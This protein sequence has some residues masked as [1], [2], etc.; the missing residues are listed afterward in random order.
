MT[1]FRVRGTRPAH[2]PWITQWGTLPP[3]Q[4]GRQG[5]TATATAYTGGG[6]GVAQVAVYWL[7]SGVTSVSLARVL[8]DGTS[9]TVRNS[10]VV[11][12]DGWAVFYD[13]E[14][15]LN[16]PVSYVAT[17]DQS[18]GNSATSA[19]L[20]LTVTGQG[21]LGDPEDPTLDV[22]LAAFTATDPA[23][24]PAEGVALQG[25]DAEKFE[26]RSGVFP[27]IGARRPRTVAQTRADA[28][29]TVRLV[30]RQLADHD[31]VDDL[32]AEGRDLALRLSTTGYGW[33]TRRYGAGWMA[34]GDATAA[35]LGSPD[36]TRA[37]RLWALPYDTVD[38]PAD[39]QTGRT[40]SNGVAVNGATFADLAATYATFAA[41][42]AAGL[43]YLTVAEGGF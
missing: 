15:P 7:S 20:T 40:L 38:A 34:V 33:A 24:D 10:P 22:A 26:A 5:P 9:E 35:R 4:T 30:S 27:I 18:P 12:S 14:A 19:P 28:S 39:T 36:M 42:A 3:Y 43:T 21:C 37:Q 16:T 41:L 31:A 8:P 25:F 23:C 2:R 13:T 29:S 11:L 1:T 32:L 6:C 17:S